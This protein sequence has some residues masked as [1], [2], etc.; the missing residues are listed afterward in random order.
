MNVGLFNCF[1][2]AAVR[3]FLR[4]TTLSATHRIDNSVPESDSPGVGD[5]QQR[6]IRDESGSQ[7]LI[8]SPS[9]N[10]SSQPRIARDLTVVVPDFD[11]RQRAFAFR[12]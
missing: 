9:L 8:R 5:I 12:K 2:T 4:R 7:Q 1:G 6:P 11:F 10:P 3:A